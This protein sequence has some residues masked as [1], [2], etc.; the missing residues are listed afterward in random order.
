M[1]LF[2]DKNNKPRQIKLKTLI[3]TLLVVATALAIGFAGNYL[4]D[5]AYQ[6]GYNK[7]ANSASEQDVIVI[8]RIKEIKG[9]MAELKK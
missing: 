7:G 2:T 1:K 9:L 6:E 8:E 3:I 4:R 5:Q